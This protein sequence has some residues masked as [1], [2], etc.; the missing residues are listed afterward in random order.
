MDVFNQLDQGLSQS[1]GHTLFELSKSQ[2]EQF[3][4]MKSHLYKK[5]LRRDL[6]LGHPTTNYIEGSKKL[7]GEDLLMELKKNI[8]EGIRC[9]HSEL[10]GFHGDR[11]RMK[12]TEIK[13]QLSDISKAE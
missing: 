4:Y 6:E 11:T 7:V 8:D 10:P 9:L 5:Q 1:R 12:L 3:L 2:F 13:T